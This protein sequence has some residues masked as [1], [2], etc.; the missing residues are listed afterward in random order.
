M[1]DSFYRFLVYLWTWNNREVIIL[2]Q[3]GHPLHG[4]WASVGMAVIFFIPL[5]IVLTLISKY[6]Y[7][8]DYQY[9]SMLND[10]SVSSGQRLDRVAPAVLSII[11]Y[12][13]P[14]SMKET[15]QTTLPLLTGL[16]FRVNCFSKFKFLPFICRKDRKCKKLVALSY[17]NHFISFIEF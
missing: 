1:R 14:Y 13:F 16:N 8:M 4:L 12:K 15:F 11:Y 6:M 10:S 7:K 9:Y 17:V 3:L 5:I 2:L